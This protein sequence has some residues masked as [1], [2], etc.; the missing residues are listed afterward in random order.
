MDGRARI[1]TILIPSS[2]D[3]C[4][5]GQDIRSKVVTIIIMIT[6]IIRSREKSSNNKCSLELTS[7]AM[8]DTSMCVR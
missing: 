4:S 2:D 5:T 1:E 3:M 6:I 7:G 8:D